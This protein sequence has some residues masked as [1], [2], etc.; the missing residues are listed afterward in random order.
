M[1]KKKLDKNQPNSTNEHFYTE[2]KPVI[3][4]QDKISK[5]YTEEILSSCEHFGVPVQI[6]CHG[7]LFVTL[8]KKKIAVVTYIIGHLLNHAVGI[9]FYSRR[10]FF[11][12][13]IISVD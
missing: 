13:A 7:K 1:H 10:H 11:H 12:L 8:Y 3:P 9:K 5:F 6:K 2:N 4:H